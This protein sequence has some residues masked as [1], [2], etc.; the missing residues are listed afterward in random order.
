MTAACPVLPNWTP[1]RVVNREVA[2]RE[3][4]RMLQLQTQ[5]LWRVRDTGFRAF[6]QPWLR[7]PRAP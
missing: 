5:H 7:Y 6:P 1:Q 4:G 3:G 2:L